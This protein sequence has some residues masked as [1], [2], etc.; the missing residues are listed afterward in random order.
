V[1]GFDPYPTNT[2]PG[3]T[4]DVLYAFVVVDDDGSE[5]IP[6]FTTPDGRVWPMVAADQARIE[7]MRPM[8]QG[9]ADQARRP[10]ELNRFLG[11]QRVEQLLPGLV[12][13][14]HAR[15]TPL[16][17][18][19]ASVAAYN[20]AHPLDEST[21]VELEHTCP[22]CYY[23]FERTTVLEG[24]DMPEGG[25]P[26]GALSLCWCGGVSVFAGGEVRR[27]TADELEALTGNALLREA[28]GL[29]SLTRALRDARGEPS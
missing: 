29:L 1:S 13:P 28:V 22:F 21:I 7:S 11:R 3:S 15:E 10:V 16:E 20:D 27:P 19:A 8:A 6:A 23:E 5:G 4:I 9:I 12:L 24:G 14:D 25:P 17:H 18:K 2:P 26:D